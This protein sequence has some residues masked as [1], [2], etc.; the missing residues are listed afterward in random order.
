MCL[1]NVLF[2]ETGCANK[3]SY[4]ENLSKFLGD[5]PE[6]KKKSSKRM[7]SFLHPSVTLTSSTQY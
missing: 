4:Q 2:D 1:V 3:I 7:D 6:L 5:G